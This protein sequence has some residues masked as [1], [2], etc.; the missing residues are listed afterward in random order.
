MEIAR[1]ETG[2]AHIHNATFENY[3]NVNESLEPP[4][5]TPHFSLLDNSSYGEHKIDWLNI[6]LIRYILPSS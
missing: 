2:A 5:P 6:L 4:N 3:E 1:L